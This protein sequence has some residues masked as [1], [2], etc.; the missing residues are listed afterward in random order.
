[1]LNGVF[2][3]VLKQILKQ[4]FDLFHNHIVILLS[5]TPLHAVPERNNSVICT[6]ITANLGHVQIKTRSFIISSCCDAAKRCKTS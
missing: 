2:S 6:C 3:T 1:M 5:H 4:C